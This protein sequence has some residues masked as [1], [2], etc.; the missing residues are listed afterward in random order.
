MAGH[1]LVQVERRAVIRR[2]G[3]R[4]GIPLPATFGICLDTQACADLSDAHTHST[5]TVHTHSKHARTHSKHARAH[6]RA[7]T[8]THTHKLFVQECLRWAFCLRC[9]SDEPEMYFSD[10]QVFKGHKIGCLLLYYWHNWSCTFQIAAANV[11]AHAPHI[12]FDM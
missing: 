9:A 6:A 7:H 8:N 11:N 2:A 10:Y 12:C 3:S 5:H 4:P 1:H